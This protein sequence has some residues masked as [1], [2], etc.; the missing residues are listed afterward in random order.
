MV[1][2]NTSIWI[3]PRV[4]REL[5]I[6]SAK[7]EK[8]VGE[9]I[10]ALLEFSKITEGNGPIRY[11]NIP[12]EHQD[13]IKTMLQTLFVAAISMAGEGTAKGGLVPRGETLEETL[14]R[15]AKEWSDERN[16]RL[17]EE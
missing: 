7:H 11:Y 9:V 5:K 14:K 6:L 8:P 13:F 12:E 16:R 3:E 2:K 10:E 17:K 1:K 15:S 4:Q